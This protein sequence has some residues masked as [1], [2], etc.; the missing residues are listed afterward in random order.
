MRIKPQTM[1]IT[2]LIQLLSDSFYLVTH[3]L[4]NISIPDG[5]SE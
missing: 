1:P 3:E 4:P 2:I 5:Q